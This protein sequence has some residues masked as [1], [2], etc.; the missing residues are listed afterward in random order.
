MWAIFYAHS[1][2]NQLIG[3][4][5]LRTPL[6]NFRLG[7]PASSAKTFA[8]FFCAT[9]LKIQRKIFAAAVADTA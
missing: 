3:W 9:R 1:L 6:A 8:P 2:R 7:S 4:L 5:S